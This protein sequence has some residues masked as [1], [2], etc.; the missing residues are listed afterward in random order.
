M[1]RTVLLLALVAGLSAPRAALA[2]AP[3]AGGS[4]VS[5]PLPNVPVGSNTEYAYLV[6]GSGAPDFTYDNPAGG[7]ARLRDL[8]AHGH[9]L[10]VFAANEEQLARLQDESDDL[11]RIGIV[12]VAVLDRRAGACRSISKKLGLSFT[13]VADPSHTIGAQYNVLDAHTRQDSPAWFVVD[14]EGRVRGLDRSDFPRESWMNVAASS[15]GLPTGDASVPA[16][17]PW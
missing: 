14:R 13:V 2:G 1:N 4:E 15:L 3:T 16:S 17:S 8:R 10:L 9:V 5:K 6:E 11:E 12:P 7:R